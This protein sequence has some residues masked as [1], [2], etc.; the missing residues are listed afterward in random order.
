MLTPHDILKKYYGFDAFR[1]P[2]ES[3]ITHAMQGKDTLALLPTGGGKSI[4]FQIPALA[5]EGICIVV[6]PLIA[7]MKDQVL[8]L[9]KRN[10]AAV[11]IF[12]GMSKS[13]IDITLDNCIY[14]AIKFLYVSPERLLTDIFLYRASQMKINFI[15]VDE[16][17]CI[18]Q[19]GY[20]FR[21]SYLRIAEFRERM[22]AIPIIALTA[23]ATG[24]VIDDIQSKLLFNENNKIFK[25]S[26]FRENLSYVVYHE[27]DKIKRMI[28]IIKK[29]AGSTIV[30]LRNRKQCEDISRILNQN[31][32]TATYYHAGMSMVDRTTKQE[33]W[34]ENKVQVMVATN[35][36]GMGIDKP[37][38]RLVL[39]LAPS[40]SLEEYYQEAGRAGRDGKKAYAVM[41]YQ[42]ADT[43]ELINR[44]TNYIVAPDV[45]RNVYQAICNYLGIAMASGKD[46][47]YPFYID[48]FNKNFDQPYYRTLRVLKILASQEYLIYDDNVFLAPRFQVLI[49]A[50][51]LYEFQVAQPSMDHFIKVL[52]RT[53]PGVFNHFVKIKYKELSHAA[54]MTIDEVKLKFEY[55]HKS[56]IIEYLPMQDTPRITMLQ[57]RM[58]ERDMILDHSLLN[59]Q[60]KQYQQRIYAIINFMTNNEQ[61][62]SEN[63][64]KYYDELDTFPCGKCDICLQYKH[65]VNFQK[66]VNKCIIL[67]SNLLREKRIEIHAYLE[68]MT[69]FQQQTTMTAIRILMDENKIKKTGSFI[70]LQK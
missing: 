65:D 10:I 36:F 31:N 49:T 9:R 54:R 61:C 12:S 70:D 15:A 2:Q 39:H 18:S 8:Q 58:L 32:I 40:E 14:G 55:L 28:H 11:A 17:H 69:K 45:V 47:S 25:K 20:D 37:D 27:E 22:P 68:G 19:W 24:H 67:I 6:T 66:E 30:Y 1:E 38:V 41:L 60:H 29:I 42:D 51:Q 59:W 52:L 13:E 46:I 16:A 33:H 7:L 62:R 53:Y 23:S 4:C 5:I 43:E 57:D 34:I 44:I 3:I 35:A 56:N 64:L 48:E 21:P 26:F 50:Q 63:L